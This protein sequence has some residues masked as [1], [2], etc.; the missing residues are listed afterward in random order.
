MIYLDNNSTTPLHPE[1]KNKIVS[2]L[3]LYGNPSSA[4][5]IGREAKSYI[6][7]AR[8]TIADF[9]KC[10]PEEIIFTASGS[11]ANNTILKS[12]SSCCS[13]HCSMGGKK[14]IISSV[15]EHPSVLNTLRCLEG[16]N[17]EITYLPVDKFGMISKESLLAA[18]RPETSLIS[19]MFANN[20]IGTIQ[21]IAEF[22]SIAKE[23]GIQFHTDAV[24]AV[25]KVDIDLSTLPIDFMSVS[26]H[27]IYAPK[28]IGLLFRRKGTHENICPLITGGHQEDSL[29]A[30]TENTIG[31]IALGE[32]FRQLKK[33]MNTEI[34][35]LI[36]LRNRLETGIK[37]NI[38]HVRLNGHPEKRLPGTLNLSFD[39]IEG[40]S[41][42]L[43]LD[44][45]GIAVSTGSA[46]SSGSLD[47][48]HVIMALGV[49]AEQA[50]GSIRFSIGRE[51]TIDD[52]EY[53]IK[54][55]KEV[56]ETL[57]RISPI[58]LK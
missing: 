41:I 28:G 46:C 1:V 44:L 42:L 3:D 11:E 5:Q 54:T 50:H 39:A 25:G 12:A 21:P 17:T 56:V 53:T 26:G 58:K 43:R 36:N 47:P 29:R 27:K 48:S 49:E 45:M 33:E 4:H 14:H 6:D 57:R 32:A 8:K 52:I 40:E 55:V 2:I 9:F 31:I 10:L 38:S 18:I 19:I 24:Q 51:N 30:G 20:E 35:H 16:E 23:K 22:A 37:E 34:P 7:E 15:I 13:K